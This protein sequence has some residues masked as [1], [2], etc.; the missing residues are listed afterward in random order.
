MNVG[1]V[2][3][4]NLAV[5]LGRAWALAGHRL[6]VAGRD[7]SRTTVAVG[8]IGDAADAVDPTTLAARSDAVVIAVAWQGIENALTLAGGPTGDLGGKTVID[9]TNPLDYVTG[10][11]KPPSGSAA[12]L[13]ARLAEGAHVVKALHLFAGSSWPYAGPQEQRPVVAIAGDDTRALKVA[14]TLVADLGARAAVVGGLDSAHSW[15]KPPDS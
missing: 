15:K 4:G 11:L 3:T 6:L 12:E 10:R 9:C 1:I 13:V 5:A 8:Q 7:R 2:G 14:S